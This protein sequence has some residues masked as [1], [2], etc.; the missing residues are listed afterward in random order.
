[1]LFS[2]RPL[3]TSL[4]HQLVK[5]LQPSLWH[6]G[7]DAEQGAPV[8]HSDKEVCCHSPP[9]PSPGLPAAR[10]AL[11]SGTPDTDCR[12]LSPPAVTGWAAAATSLC[13]R[14]RLAQPL[15]GFSSSSCPIS[16]LVSKWVCV[17]SFFWVSFALSVSLYVYLL[18]SLSSLTSSLFLVTL[19]VS[20]SF[21]LSSPFLKPPEVRSL[22]G[23]QNASV[24]HRDPE[25]AAN[26]LGI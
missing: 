20:F 12:A 7:Q 5:N 6:A 18:C 13:L 8:R 2:P 9:Q 16:F 26:F 10:E 24:Q 25:T 15:T 14:S 23:S 17:F 21:S 4:Y 19:S 22:R 11:C 3:H 1:M